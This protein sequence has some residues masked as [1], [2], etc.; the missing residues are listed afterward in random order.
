MCCKRRSDGSYQFS[1]MTSLWKWKS[2]LYSFLSLSFSPF[3]PFFFFLISFLSLFPFFSSLPFFTHSFHCI[4]SWH[5]RISSYLLYFFHKVSTHL[6]ASPESSRVLIFVE[7]L[8]FINYWLC[9][10]TYSRRF[11]VFYSQHG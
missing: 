10:L 9:L 7:F 6:L 2:N 5:R 11:A 4:V 3:S 8:W 1:Q